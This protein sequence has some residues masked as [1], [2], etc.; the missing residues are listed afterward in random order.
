MNDENFNMSIRKFLKTVGVNSQL[1]IEKAVQKAVADGRLKGKEAFPAAMTL[2]VAAYVRTLGLVELLFTF[3]VGRIA[4]R[5]TPTAREVAGAAL[6]AAGIALL[7]AIAWIVFGRSSGTAGSLASVSGL[8]PR[9]VAVLYFTDQSP[10][11]SLGHLAD[12]LTEALID[13]L[14]AAGAERE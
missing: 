13:Q 9:R 11:S 3:A 12:G 14:V 10:D 5:E 1:A 4:F 8:D 6:L 2:T 7:V